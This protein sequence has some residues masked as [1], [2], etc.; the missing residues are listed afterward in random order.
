MTLVGRP[1]LNHPQQTA[2]RGTLEAVD[3]RRT[4]RDFFDKLNDE[5]RF[6]LDAAATDENALCPHY[7]TVEDD[8]LS[9]PWA[10]H[11]VWCNP[12]YSDCGAWVA[13]AWHE[14]RLGVKCV[15]ML[16]PANRTEQKWWQRDVEPYRDERG[17]I[18][19]RFLPGR[20]R[21]DVPS[22]TYSDPRGNRPPFGCVLVIWNRRVTC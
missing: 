14:Y 20:M 18:E 15:V 19:T 4:P 22:G 16:L 6:T 9:K 17:P 13:K 11:R 3:D 1:A 2:R 10:W 21:F 8:G 5:F 7:F 12:P